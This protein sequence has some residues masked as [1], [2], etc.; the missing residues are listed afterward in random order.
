M[1]PF[2]LTMIKNGDPG[3]RLPIRGAAARRFTERNTS[4]RGD[5]PVTV[6]A[7]IRTLSTHSLL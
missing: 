7:P 5:G 3:Y 1:R 6:E 2:T 4:Q